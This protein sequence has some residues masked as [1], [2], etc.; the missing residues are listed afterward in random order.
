MERMSLKKIRHK[1][2]LTLKEFE[3]FQKIVNS[4]SAKER[5]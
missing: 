4:C 1:R 5:C 3:D 2:D